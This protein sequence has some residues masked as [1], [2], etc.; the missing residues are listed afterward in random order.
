MPIYPSSRQQELDSTV[1]GIAKH[2]VF[3]QHALIAVFWSRADGTFCKCGVWGFHFR[4]QLQTA[5]R[6]YVLNTHAGTRWHAH[7]I[8]HAARRRELS[9][10]SRL[11]VV[12]HK[13]IKCRA[14]GTERHA[15][16]KKMT[17]MGQSE[18]ERQSGRF[19]KRKAD[20]STLW[21]KL[22]FEL[23]CYYPS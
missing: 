2:S 20:Y 10:P 12:S 18:R 9:I 6:T 7:D 8:K 11:A 15:K 21:Q 17:E 4:L 13:G 19:T 14:D 1:I 22:S 16:K 23:P 3:T 5:P